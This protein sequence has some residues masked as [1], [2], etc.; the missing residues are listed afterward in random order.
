LPGWRSS[1]RIES[2]C[3]GATLLAAHADSAPCDPRPSKRARFMLEASEDSRLETC[4][5][6][7]QAA[8]GHASFAA[9][10]PTAPQARYKCPIPAASDPS[11][12]T[13]HVS[14]CAPPAE[15]GTAANPIVIDDSDDDTDSDV[16]VCTVASPPL[17]AQVNMGGYQPAVQ[18]ALVQSTTTVPMGVDQP[19]AVA[20]ALPQDVAASMA[21]FKSVD[22]GAATVQQLQTTKD[23]YA[24]IGLSLARLLHL[25][26][27]NNNCQGTHMTVSALPRLLADTGNT[28]LGTAPTLGITTNKAWLKRAPSLTRLTTL[29]ATMAS[30]SHPTPAHSPPGVLRGLPPP[31]NEDE[32]ADPVAVSR[33]HPTDEPSAVVAASAGDLSSPPLFWCSQP[34]RVPLSF[35]AVGPS[36]GPRAEMCCMMMEANDAAL[37][38]AVAI[39]QPLPA[40]EAWPT[41]NNARD[42]CERRA[43]PLRYDTMPK[44]SWCLITIPPSD[45]TAGFDCVYDSPSPAGG[46]VAAAPPYS[47]GHLPTP[48]N[49]AS[50]AVCV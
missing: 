5:R 1:R 38:A 45:S 37:R 12:T 44:P 3:A 19:T 48:H 22:Q 50:A 25:A 35:G 4:T 15:C 40:G 14:S 43:P 13:A 34:T 49:Q 27:Y 39:P 26:D 33:R 47:Q 32:P 18:T 23:S 8:V 17:Q 2:D 16:S 24:T 11:P 20:D 31:V 42:T 28:L 6:T 10:M 7:S 36:A 46:P 9:S 21:P 41:N 29:L 30:H